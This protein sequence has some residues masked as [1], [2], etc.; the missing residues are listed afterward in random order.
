MSP[1]VTS[2]DPLHLD[3]HE[4]R[5][6]KDT[7][8]HAWIVLSE[9]RA[10]DLASPVEVIGRYA[11]VS[12]SAATLFAVTW[13][14]VFLFWLAAYAL[15]TG[16][17]Y[18]LLLNIRPENAQ[19]HM[20][21]MILLAMVTS[22]V[23]TSMPLW[24]WLSDEIASFK[25]L[26]VFAIVGLAM[27]NIHRHH[28]WSAIAIWDCIWTIL[29][30]A[31]IT[32]LY[33]PDLPNITH[34]SVV[35][36]GFVASATYFVLSLHNTIRDRTQLRASQTRA[37]VE[38]KAHTT[39]Q[40]TAGIAHDFNNTLTA[41][42]GHIELAEITDDPLE[43]Q[44]L[45]AQAKLSTKRAGKVVTQMRAYAGKSRLKIENVRLAEYLDVFKNEIET[46]T[47]WALQ[48][49]V[50][51]PQNDLSIDVDKSLLHCALKHLVCNAHEAMAHSDGNI[52]LNVKTTR[53]G[54]PKAHKK[55]NA[56]D[57]EYV[58]FDIRDAGPGIEETIM[59]KVMDPFFTTK[60]PGRAAGLG[61]SMVKGFAK[62]SGGF[63]ELHNLPIAGLQASLILPRTRPH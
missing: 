2:H 36:V 30:A 55:G 3:A 12:L 13:N 14:W 27:F 32:A 38:Q 26:A 21:P 58:Q 49:D 11:V 56:T 53:L 43:R 29:S 16:V 51:V 34:Y 37:V 44:D 17:F 7:G 6:P 28:R 24:L 45:L 61:L 57:V 19:T 39:H 25:A 52:A 47:S 22:V 8:A 60:A 46:S 9:L 42:Q 48:L 10:S 15:S 63:L 50:T 62:Q 4:R 40:L 18:G 23:F 1:V 33:L 5:A 59:H 54:S 31:I 35:L 41:I 20:V